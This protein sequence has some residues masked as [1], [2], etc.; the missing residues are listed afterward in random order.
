MTDSDLIDELKRIDADE[1]LEV[2]DFE[3]DFLDTIIRSHQEYLSPKQ[4][5]VA[6]RMVDEYLS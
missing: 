2:T 1:D 5:A 6:K 4:R 3:A